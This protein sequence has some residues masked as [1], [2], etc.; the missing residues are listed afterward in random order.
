MWKATFL[1]LRYRFQYSFSKSDRSTYDFSNLGEDFFST[2][3][4]AYRNWNNY[5]NLLSNP[6]TS[7]LD[8]DFEP[9]LFV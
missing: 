8:S 6:W 7:Y 4:P 1:Q 2:V 9:I 5:L 3:S